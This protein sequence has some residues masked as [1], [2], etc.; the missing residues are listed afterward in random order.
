METFGKSLAN[1]FPPLF[2]YGFGISDRSFLERQVQIIVEDENIVQCALLERNGKEL[3]SAIKKAPLPD[4][5]LIYRFSHPVQSQEEQ[6]IGTVQMGISLHRFRARVDALKRDIL[7]VTLG[8]I[9]LGFLFTIILTRI[10]LRP[11]EK[12]VAATEIV[13]RGELIY[14]VDID[15]GDEIGDLARAFNQMTLQ[16]KGSRTDLEKKVEERTRLL[17]ENIKELN[18]ARTSTL[19]MLEDLQSAKKELEMM[20]REVTEMDE[21]RMKFIGT[22]SH[23]LK[24]PLTAIK[25]TIDF[26]LSDK[27]VKVPENL[28][29]YL[30]PIQRKKN[31]IQ[32][33]MDHMLDLTRIRSG[34]LLPPREMILFWEGITAYTHGVKPVQ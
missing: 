19:K 2:R 22:A 13:A 17:E 3:V 12:L 24:T 10:L 15:S 28:K 31:R 32:G 25:A 6:L 33:T 30:L 34:R 29:S 4:P 1:A 14:T 20:N 27:E 23:E 11:I 8:V 26:I 16:L 9:G 5:D 18:R 7:F 21:T